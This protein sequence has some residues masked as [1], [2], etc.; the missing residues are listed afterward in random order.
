MKEAMQ[1]VGVREDDKFARSVWRIRWYGHVLRTEEEYVG[2]IVLVIT[3]GDVGDKKER[4]TEAE[5]VGK[6]QE[7]L[8]REKCQG[9]MRK[10]EFNGGVS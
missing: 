4:K 5:V 7:R 9:R 6:H 2:K 8:V 3:P 10:N 1:E